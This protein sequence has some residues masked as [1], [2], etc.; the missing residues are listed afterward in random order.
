M[1]KSPRL[2]IYCQSERLMWW[3]L[4]RRMVVLAE[5]VFDFMFGI[6]NFAFEG[7][8]AKQS[9]QTVVGE[10]GFADTISTK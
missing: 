9:F 10:G 1:K 8:E 5:V 4:E 3:L 7:V 2:S 6:E